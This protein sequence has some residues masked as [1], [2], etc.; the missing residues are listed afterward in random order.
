MPVLGLLAVLSIFLF[1]LT[2]RPARAAGLF[3]STDADTVA[4][5]SLI[6]I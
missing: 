2:A 1:S 4:D 5:L 6:H 3:V